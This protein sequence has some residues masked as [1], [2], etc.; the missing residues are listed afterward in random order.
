MSAP[1]AMQSADSAP[2][3]RAVEPAVAAP[4]AVP[5]DAANPGWFASDFEFLA[6]SG[7]VWLVLALAVVALLAWI[8]A[9]RRAARARLADAAILARIAPALSGTRHALRSVLVALSALALGVALLDPRAGGRVEKVEQQGIDV[10]V[11]VDVSRSMLAEDAAPDRLTRAK[12]FASDLVESLGSDRVGLIEFA[13]VPAM[14]CPLT[15]NH[16][17]FRTQLDALSPQATV[18]GGSL[19]GDAIRLAAESLGGESSG[20][21]DRAGDGVGRAIVVLSDGEDMES[22][23]VEAA[24]TAAT[25]RGIRIVTIGLGNKA[26][27]ARIPLDGPGSR[28]YLVHEG[29]EVWTKMDPRLLAEVAEAGGGFFVEAGTGQADMREVADLLAAGMERQ[30]RERRDVSIKTPLFQA[31]A[32]IAL[33]ALVLES[34]VPIR[35]TPR[36]HERGST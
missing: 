22:A 23:P 34:L 14:R 32:V 19:L 31:L 9:W 1:I 35:A 25:E 13:G 33:V 29:Q 3:A 8:A 15:F 16:R 21:D 24:A 30:S 18:R 27:G 6:P 10:M 2:E 26:E 20:E 12:Q 7:A 28:R 11:V 5:A 17:S 4:A 36:A